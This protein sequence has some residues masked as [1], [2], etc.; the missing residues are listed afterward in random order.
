M[1]KGRDKRRRAKRRNERNRK[2]EPAHAAEPVRKERLRCPSPGGQAILS[3]FKDQLL[4]IDPDYDPDDCFSDMYLMELYHV[5][6][7][8]IAFSP[9]GRYVYQ[10]SG[11]GPDRATRIYSVLAPCVRPIRS[12]P[13]VTGPSSHASHPRKCWPMGPKAFGAVTLGR[14]APSARLELRTNHRSGRPDHR[15]VPAAARPSEPS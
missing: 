11:N 14:L 3:I 8:P 7:D 5:D 12:V 9:S 6:R 1:G 15:R 10:Q 13:S 4:F 2:D